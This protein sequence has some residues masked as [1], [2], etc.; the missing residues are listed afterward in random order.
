MINVTLENILEELKKKELN[1]SIQEDT[2]QVFVSFKIHD[3]DFPMFIKVIHDGD[4]IQILHFIP[5]HL[6]KN[7]ASDVARLMHYLNKEMDLPGFGYDENNQMMFFR[8]LLPT[9]NKKVDSQLLL[10]FV[11]AARIANETFA[12]MIQNVNMGKTRFKEILQKT[13]Q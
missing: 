2:Q 1:P 7:H 10:A 3:T 13:T 11:N 6:D 8:L 5:A 9:H 12:P 4:L